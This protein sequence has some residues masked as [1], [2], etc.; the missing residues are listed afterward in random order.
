MRRVIAALFLAALALPCG[1]QEVVHALRHPISAGGTIAPQGT[2]VCSTT[3]YVTSYAASYT[4][5]AAGDQVF[6]SYSGTPTSITNN[7]SQTAT[8][9]L[10]ASGNGPYVG[11]FSSVASGVTTI[12]L[13]RASA[14]DTTYCIADFSG[15][16]STGNTSQALVTTTGASSPWVY[17]ESLSTTQ[18][19]GYILAFESDS[20]S[21]AEVP[22]ATAGTLPVYRNV[23]YGNEF[24]Q[25][26]TS[27][28][29]GSL[30]ISGTITGPSANVSLGMSLIELKH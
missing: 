1:G 7:Q 14:S 20:N 15:V 18:A 3:D 4:P 12:T 11:W 16:A 19:N 8:Q 27:A 10:A 2:W 29:A 24:L 21:V 23:A 13:N 5:H 26:N 25:Y 28:T 6:V 22:T 30:P 17:T 9:I